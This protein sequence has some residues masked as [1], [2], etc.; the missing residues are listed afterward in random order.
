MFR[1][2][3][4][5]NHLQR[6][7][8]L[9]FELSSHIAQID[10]AQ[11]CSLFDNSTAHA[12][13][14]RHHTL[15]M[16][17]S[18]IFVKRIPVTNIEY[19]NLFSTKNLYDLPMYYHYGVGSAGFGVF[20]ELLTHIKT[21]NWVLAGAIATFPLMY[22]YRII[23]ISGARADVDLE[24]HKRYVEYWGDNANVGRYLLDRA[25]ANYEAVLFLE[26]IPHT[27]VTW[28]RENPRKIH[29]VIADMRTTI[30]FLR[31]HGILH[32]DSHFFNV[33]AD[34]QRCYLTDFGLVLDKSFALTQAEQLFYKKNI[35]YDYGQLSWGLG[36]HL[37]GMYRRLPDADKNR[38]AESIGLSEKARFEEE[39]RRLLDK[40]DEIHAN[41]MMKL[42]GRFVTSLRKYRP[43]IRLMNDFYSDL[44]Q[45]NKKDTRFKHTK[46]QRL[47]KEAGFLA[48]V[49]I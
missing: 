4:G 27:V 45:N 42:D 14:G 25:N 30:T 38:V 48:N 22:H 23:P 13:W 1:E 40:I 31:N 11:L 32:L 46:L 5:K 29:R 34:G 28:L 3:Y 43:L 17:Q 21:T 33:L 47:L 15:V 35:Y 2:G 20:R 18:K 9:Y 7:R 37:V 24:R 19:D 49:K 10:N 36:C 26:H 6:R 44:Q 12:G 41:R 16:G 8:A 39:M